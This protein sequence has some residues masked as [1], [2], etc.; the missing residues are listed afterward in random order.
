MSHH[1]HRIG[2]HFR[3]Q[4]VEEACA[5]LGYTIRRGRFVKEADLQAQHEQNRMAQILARHGVQMNQQMERETPTQVRAAI[6]ELFPRIPE[7]D[8][9][10]IVQHAWEKDSRR[11]GT[12][13]TLDLPRRVQLAVIARIR[14]TYTDYDFLLKAFEWKEARRIT[15]PGCL[16][17]L[18][19]W[20]GEHDDENDNELEEIVRETIV[21]DDDDVDDTV[22]GSEADDEDSAAELGDTSDGSIEFTHELAADEDLGAESVDET[23]KNFATR[24]QQWQRRVEAQN[25]IA[26]QKI[27]AARQQLRNGPPPQAPYGRLQDRADHAL[28]GNRNAPPLHLRAIERRE[29]P[30]AVRSAAQVFCMV[31]AALRIMV[32]RLACPLPFSANIAYIRRKRHDLY[33]INSP[34]SRRTP[35][36]MY[37]FRRRMSRRQHSH[38][39]ITLT[40]HQP[41]LCTIARSS[42]SSRVNAQQRC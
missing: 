7:E 32:E 22:N 42:L 40:L 26:R 30:D 28:T 14:H 33:H 8:L 27:G 13:A 9:E 23:S 39:H 20:R 18:I 38:L 3:A 5:E 1:V 29:A 15:E 35:R 24:P 16:Q 11:V 6:K 21:I 10:Q 25:N 31:R 34:L 12:N 19:E 2:Y 4:I 17:K 41:W 36:M 37:D